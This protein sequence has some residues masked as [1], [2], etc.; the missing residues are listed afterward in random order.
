MNK[1][2]KRAISFVCEPGKLVLSG[3]QYRDVAVED[4]D[5]IFIKFDGRRVAN[6]KSP[7]DSQIFYKIYEEAVRS[8]R[9]CL[10]YNGSRTYVIEPEANIEYD[11]VCDEIEEIS[12]DSLNDAIEMMEESNK[13]RDDFEGYITASRMKHFKNWENYF[14]AV[15][16]HIGFKLTK[17]VPDNL[18]DFSLFLR[19]NLTLQGKTIYNINDHKEEDNRSNRMR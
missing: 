7:E 8:K 9:R 13:T 18:P 6:L 12:L 14:T 4:D 16:D 3:G 1:Q 2:Q 15:A 19:G 5:G 11:R 10:S 17:I